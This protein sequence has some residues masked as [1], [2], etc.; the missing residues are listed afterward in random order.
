MMG[1]DALAIFTTGYA[2][3]SLLHARGLG[4]AAAQVAA[5]H[6]AV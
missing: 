5:V 1:V 2:L 6:R 3:V 4:L